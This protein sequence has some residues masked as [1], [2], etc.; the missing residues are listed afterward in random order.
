MDMCKFMNRKRIRNP[1]YAPEFLERKLS[2]SAFVGVLTT[3]AAVVKVDPGSNTP[4]APTPA[5]PSPTNL[6]LTDPT[7]PEDGNGFPPTNDPYPLPPIGP[8]VPA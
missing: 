8:E 7:M 2:P 1:R 6:Y 4:T 3:P 5:N